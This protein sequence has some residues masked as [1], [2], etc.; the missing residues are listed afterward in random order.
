MADSGV[1]SHVERHIDGERHAVLGFEELIGGNAQVGEDSVDFF[2]F[3]F[4]EDVPEF[5]KVGVEEADFTGG[6]FEALTGE[7]EILGVNIEADEAA[8]GAEVFGDFEGVTG[9]AEGAVD[10]GFAG[11]W[12]EEVE[13][14][15][16]EDGV[17]TGGGE[18]HGEWGKG[19]T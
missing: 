15:G 12:G 3:E 4:F 14:F 10:D 9:A 18:I 19:G 17:V 1:N 11:G 7:G 8:G 5:G 2:D 13:N 6:G 16:H